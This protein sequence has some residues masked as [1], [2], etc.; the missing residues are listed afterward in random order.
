ME[1]LLFFEI[2]IGNIN[3][4]KIRNTTLNTTKNVNTNRI[5][6]TTPNRDRKTKYKQTGKCKNNLKNIIVNY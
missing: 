6:N 4:D 1:I 2:K 3:T 5:R